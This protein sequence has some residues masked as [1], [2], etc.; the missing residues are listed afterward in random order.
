M[1]IP[2]S[3]RN[4]NNKFDSTSDNGIFDEDPS[5]TLVLLVDFKS[6][7]HALLPE[8]SRQLEPLR[9]RDYLSY[10]DGNNFISRAITIV[11]SGDA[12]FDDLN[13]HRQYRDIFFDAPLD[14]MYEPAAQDPTSGHHQHRSQGKTGTDSISTPNAFN[15]SNSYYASTSF[16]S[17]IGTPWTGRLSAHQLDL[18]RGQIRGAKRRG[19]KAR[20][21][22]TPAWPTSLRNHVWEVLVREGAEVLTVDDLYAAAYVDWTAHVGHGWFDA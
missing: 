8:V 20:Y 3:D 2:P 11:A 6:D 15:T 10:W 1:L 19:L 4:A 13:H 16:S 18:L 9:S 14:E 21:W 12:P 5:Q 22:E 7:G 17:S